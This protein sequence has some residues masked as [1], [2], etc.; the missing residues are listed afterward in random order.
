MLFLHW[1]DCYFGIASTDVK[2]E[3]KEFQKA[4]EVTELQKTVA[5]EQIRIQLLESL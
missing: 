4:D 1:E 5:T 2:V 3:P